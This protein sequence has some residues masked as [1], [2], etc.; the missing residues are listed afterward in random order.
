MQGF[1]EATWVQEC[2]SETR[3]ALEQM[4]PVMDKR[5]TSIELEHGEDGPAIVITFVEREQQTYRTV[6]ALR[7]SLFEGR[8]GP[9]SPANVATLIYANLDESSGEG[10]QWP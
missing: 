3:R 4:A 8:V 9:A 6:W 2:L 10:L 5:V 7:S 1:D